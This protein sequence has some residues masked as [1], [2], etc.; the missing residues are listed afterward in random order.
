MNLLFTEEGARLAHFGQKDAE[1]SFLEDGTWE[2]N[3]DLTTVAEVVMP[4]RTIGTGTAARDYPGRIP[5]AVQG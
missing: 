5:G 3:D 4:Q 2:W 1:Y